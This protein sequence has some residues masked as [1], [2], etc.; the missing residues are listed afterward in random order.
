MAA[1]VAGSL[2][3]SIAVGEAAALGAMV[4]LGAGFGPVLMTGF[5][6]LARVLPPGR[7]A[8]GTSLLYGLGSL[9]DP[10]SGAPLAAAASAFGWRA[11]MLGMTLLAAASAVLG[12]RALREVPGAGASAAA[13]PLAAARAVV[14]IRDLWF[15]V[16]L[17]LV[18]YAVI[19]ATRGLWI[20]PYLAGVHGLDREAISLGATA[21]GFAI[22]GGGLLYA[23]LNRLFGDAKRTVAFGLAVTAVAWLALGI[24]GAGSTTAAIALLLFAATFGAH[25][26]IVISHARTLLP[27]HLLGLGVTL[28]NLVFFGGAALVQWLSG[29]YVGAAEAAGVAPASVYGGLFCGFGVALVTALAV[30]AFAPGERR[31]VLQP[32][33]SAG[34]LHATEQ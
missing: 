10:L 21:M 30:Y 16:P 33:S 25:F 26:A 20:A 13:S 17:S 7:F 22:A 28:V 18:S 31:R 4:L 34:D 32:R 3:F 29:R 8:A 12:W 14:S 11:T 23:P 27:T 19:A 5:Y 9:G 15:L 2:L 24:V 6:V 1:A